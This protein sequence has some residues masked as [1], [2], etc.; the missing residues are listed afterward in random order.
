MTEPMFMGEIMST[1]YSRPVDRRTFLRSAAAAIPLTSALLSTGRLAAQDAKLA[2]GGLIIREK[3][4]LNLEFPFATLDS[5]ITPNEKFYVRNHFPIPELEAKT[6]KLKVDGAVKKELELTYDQIRKLPSKTVMATLEC[7]GNGRTSLKPK[8]KGVQWDLGAVSNAEWTGV[9]LSAVLEAAGLDDGAVEVVLEG[10]DRGE[11]KTDIRPAN[12]VLH[13]ARS[14]PLT[15]VR[16]GEVLL[17]YQMNGKELPVNHGFPLRAIVPGWFGMASIKWLQRLI[18][19]KQPFNGFFET[20]DYSYFSTS[21]G[22]PEVL[23]I[24]ELQVK[25]QIARPK[26]GE[27]VDAKAKYRIHGA[28]WTG[29]SDI[30]KVE[31]SF[32]DG[33]TWREAT[34]G[35]RAVH[36]AWRF[37]EYSWTPEKAGAVSIMA[38]ATDARGVTQPMKR[39]PNR[40]NYII[41]HVVPLE[42]TVK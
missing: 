28:A 7:A 32:D 11:V 16:K 21:K 8:A 19:T 24:Q 31:L 14:L 5:F 35:D 18:V 25:A 36:F 34:L 26:P 22:V 23:P 15:K 42:V 39:D 33:K 40:R 30:R 13:F 27:V 38:R 29:E 3:D 1:P 12:P 6:W 17:A 37:W 2:A 10:A 41:N 9:P 20:I 4:P